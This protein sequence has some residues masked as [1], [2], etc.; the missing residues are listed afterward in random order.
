MSQ[1]ASGKVAPKNKLFWFRLLTVDSQQ[2]RLRLRSALTLSGVVPL[3]SGTLRERGS[4]LRVAATIGEGSTVFC[5]IFFY[6]EVPKPLCFA[7]FCSFKLN[8][9]SQ[10]RI[11]EIAMLQ[12]ELRKKILTF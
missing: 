11:E 10:T 6:L 7:K 5:G 12:L 4:K 8:P 9:Q 1:Y 2:S 3:P